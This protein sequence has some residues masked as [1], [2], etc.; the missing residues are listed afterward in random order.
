MLW[1]TVFLCYDINY[2]RSMH[3]ILQDAGSPLH[4]CSVNYTCVALFSCCTDILEHS[5]VTQPNIK[6]P[7][8]MQLE[9][10]LQW[11]RKAA[12]AFYG[13]LFEEMSRTNGVVGTA[14]RLGLDGLGFDPRWGK[15]I[16]ASL[17]LIQSGRRAYTAS[18]NGNR[19]CFWG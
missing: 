3:H 13:V 11:P 9:D 5:L 12:R 7:C 2:G 19:G 18:S 8:F 6:F 16:F 10:L 17:S 14:T 1:R 15:E 4:R